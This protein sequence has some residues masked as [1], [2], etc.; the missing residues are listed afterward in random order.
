[1]ANAARTPVIRGTNVAA[2]DTATLTWAAA[3]VFAVLAINNLG[4]G[5]VGMAFGSSPPA[6]TTPATD[7]LVL[8]SGDKVAFENIQFE[9]VIAFRAD[10]T[11]GGAD[12]SAYA[13]MTPEGG[14][15]GFGD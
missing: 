7:V 5:K 10:A 14:V 12:I 6:N 8:A 2:S 11:V 9:G 15:G 3:G 1:M 4:P 13:V